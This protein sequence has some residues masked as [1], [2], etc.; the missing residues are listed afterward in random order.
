MAVKT[1]SAQLSPV[2]ITTVP[3]V[4]SFAEILSSKGK[5]AVIR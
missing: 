2:V 1:P 3:K 4:E 5:P